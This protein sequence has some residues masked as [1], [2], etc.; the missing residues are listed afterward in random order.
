MKPTG[1]GI[2]IVRPVNGLPVPMPI[3]SS[4]P[5]ISSAI[6]TRQLAARTGLRKYCP[7][8]A[9]PSLTGTRVASAASTTNVSRHS[10]LSLTQTCRNPDAPAACAMSSSR[11]SECRR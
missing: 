11:V 3:T 7:M 9:V 10:R 1:R 6:G 2:S 4:R 5:S 8:I